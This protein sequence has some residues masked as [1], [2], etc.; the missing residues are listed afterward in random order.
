MSEQ[1]TSLSRGLFPAGLELLHVPAPGIAIV[2]KKSKPSWGLLTFFPFP[3]F[4]SFLLLLL[5]WPCLCSDRHSRFYRLSFSLYFFLS[6]AGFVD[7]TV[8]A[9]M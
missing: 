4:E 2:I 5:L 8:Q 6:L 9:R 3:H 7:T 1:Q